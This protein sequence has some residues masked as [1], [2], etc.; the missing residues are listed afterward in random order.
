MS[1]M[2]LLRKPADNPG[3]IHAVMATH[4]RCWEWNINCKKWETDKIPTS[5]GYFIIIESENGRIQSGSEKLRILVQNWARELTHCWHSLIVSHG[6][7]PDCQQPVSP[8]H[9]M[10]N[11]EGHMQCTHSQDGEGEF[12]YILVNC[13]NKRKTNYLSQRL[14]KS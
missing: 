10:G 1:E 2:L 6:V 4:N 14:Y 8:W 3:L 7:G 5:D 11:S 9:D 12:N 13:V